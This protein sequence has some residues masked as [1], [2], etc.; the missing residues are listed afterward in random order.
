[1]F[2]VAID[3]DCSTEFP[4]LYFGVRRS[5]VKTPTNALALARVIAAQWNGLKLVGLMG[6][7]GQ[8]AGLQD[9]A[10][11][12]GVRNTILKFLK[13]SSITEISQRRSATVAALRS[14]GF[15]LD[16]CQWRWYR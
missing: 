9:D 15:R 8:I 1:M 11:G 16:F 5:P 4:H 12:Q 2:L 10:P 3:L 14:A 13:R 6:Y 7:E